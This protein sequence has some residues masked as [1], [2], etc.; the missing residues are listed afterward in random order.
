MINVDKHSFHY[1]DELRI[2]NW[3]TETKSPYI[4][5]LYSLLGFSFEL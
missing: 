4:F 2:E 3:E 5:E 1:S